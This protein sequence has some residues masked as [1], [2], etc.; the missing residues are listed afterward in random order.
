MRIALNRTAAAFLLAL[1]AVALPC[2][3]WFVVG[4]REAAREAERLEEGPRRLADAAVRQLADRLAARLEALRDN[5]DKRPFYHY[6]GLYHDPKGAYEGTSV[7]PSPLLQG[8]DDPLIEA[9]FQIDPAG[10]LTLPTLNDE[11]PQADLSQE[12]TPQQ[13]DQQRA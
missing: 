3:S 2:G 10:R 8:P 1:A 5:E 13:L 9:H 7:V 6:Q 11:I 12:L 4:S